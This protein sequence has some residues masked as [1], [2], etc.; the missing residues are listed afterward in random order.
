MKT[1]RVRAQGHLR[2]MAE[3]AG[4]IAISR[5][6]RASPLRANREGVAAARLS[7]VGGRGLERC[8]PGGDPR[9]AETSSN[10]GARGRGGRRG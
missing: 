3:V 8:A 7:S 4:S 6:A 5:L 9:P 2:A 10:D 1:G